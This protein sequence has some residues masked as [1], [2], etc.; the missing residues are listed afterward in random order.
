MRL[1][2]YLRF[3]HGQQVSGYGWNK[4]KLT[5][6]FL[7]FVITKCSERHDPG[8]ALHCAAKPGRLDLVDLSLDREADRARIIR[9][10]EPCI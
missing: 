4:A 3:A 1:Q 5:N 8:K 6:E 10:Q 2:D 7:C 9:V